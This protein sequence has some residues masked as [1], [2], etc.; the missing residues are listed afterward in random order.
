MFLYYIYILFTP[1]FYF[2]YI[3]SI[4]N[5]KVRSNLFLY[6]K[7]LNDVYHKLNKNSKTVILFHAASAGEFEQLKPILTRID[8]KKFFI[9]QSFT[10]STIYNSNTEVNQISWEFIDQKNQIQ[11]I[12]E[13]EMR[14]FFPDTLNRLLIDSKFDINN[15]YG[16]YE[17]ENF[18]EHSEKQIY[19]CKK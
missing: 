19:I 7:T 16:S 5:S 6:K 10:S 15:F 2:I 8:R 17:L 18:N 4:F 14:M 9:V 11:F 13:F 1:F 3:A 12:Y